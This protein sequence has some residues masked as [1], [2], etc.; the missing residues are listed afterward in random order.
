MGKVKSLLIALLSLACPL[1]ICSNTRAGALLLNGA[2]LSA[3]IIPSEESNFSDI[4]VNSESETSR[5]SFAESVSDSENTH[6]VTEDNSSGNFASGNESESSE[7][8]SDGVSEDN[9]DLSESQTLPLRG[10]IID[11]NRSTLTDDTDYSVFTEESGKIYRYSYGRFN[12]DDYINLPSGAQVRNCTDISNDVLEKAAGELPDY[13]TDYDYSKPQVLIYHTHTSESFLPFS[14]TYDENYPIRSVDDNRNIVA[15]GD[16]VCNALSERGISVVHDCTVHDYPMYTGAYYRSAET[17]L[18]NLEEYPDIKLVIDIHRDGIVNG[19]GSLY[20][21]VAEIDGKS[22]AQFMLIS[23]CDNGEFDMPN[24]MENF[25]LACLLQNC[26]ERAF[27]GLARPVLFDY[28]NYN[29]S[30]STGSLLIE[31]G[32]HGNSLEEAVYTGEL[33]GN[34]IADALDILRNENTGL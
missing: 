31:V 17:I 18:E 32:S 34:A 28:R 13:G 26:S 14:D 20:A 7:D 4:P 19:D 8:N 29:Q 27:P 24:Y 16:A 12:S 21:P 23:C 2:Y 25:R 15:V 33:L 22:A 10:R 3:G 6:E 1:L 11:K 9:S 30:L 5:V